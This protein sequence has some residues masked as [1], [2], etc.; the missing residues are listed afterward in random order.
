[1]LEDPLSGVE[2]GRSWVPHVFRVVQVGDGQ[3][4][5]EGHQSGASGCRGG[6]REKCPVWTI[7]RTK[8]AW[9]SK[10]GAPGM[11]LSTAMMQKLKE[12]MLW[13]F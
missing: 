12:K 4:Q 5:G 7:A 9:S 1:M 11:D 6:G 10:S 2:L 13:D 8:I 3:V